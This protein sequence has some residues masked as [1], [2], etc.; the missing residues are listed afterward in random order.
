MD[1]PSER[2]RR[3]TPFFLM[4]VAP[5]LD[6]AHDSGIGGR[7]SDPLCLKGLYERCFGVARR[8]ACKMLAR[9][10]V[11]EVQGVPFFISGR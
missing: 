10:K 1:R 2:Q 9:V 11:R 6:S 4:D 8:R 3:K 7:A 5:L